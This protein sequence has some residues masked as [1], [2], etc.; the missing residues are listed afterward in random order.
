MLRFIVT[1]CVLVVVSGCDSTKSFDDDEGYDLTPALEN[2]AVNVIT[3]TYKDLDDAV[4][5]FHDALDA[6]AS[7]RASAELHTAQNSWVAARVFWESSEAFLFGPVK[8]K[9]LDTA[10]DTWPVTESDVNAVLTNG[11]S[12]SPDLIESLPDVHKGF[13]TIEFLLFGEDGQK[14]ADDLTTRELAYLVATTEVLTRSSQELLEA[15]ASEGENFAANLANAGGSGSIYSSQKAAVEELMSGLI[16]IADDV[17]NR[18]I[19]TPL[20]DQ[21]V[22]M[23]ESR[24]S[25]NSINDF[26]NNLRSIRNVYTG[27]YAGRSGPGLTDF[28]AEQDEVLDERFVQEVD[29]AIEAIG[30]I[31]GSFRDAIFDNAEAVTAAQNAVGTVLQTLEQDIVPI[32]ANL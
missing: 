30:N 32:V 9:G 16:F 27:E 12:L 26:Q 11:M 31:P 22:L 15:W 7:S 21:D 3:L 19:A 13:H 14:L 28:I 8:S 4:G 1:V 10:L 17:A 25:R 2:I 24:F 18:K 23:I 5:D 20:E 29:A 6:F